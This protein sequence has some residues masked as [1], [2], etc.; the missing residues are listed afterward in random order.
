LITERRTVDVQ[1]TT[2]LKT[3]GMA[4]YDLYAASAFVAQAQRI[5][6]GTELDP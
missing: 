5:G 3:V 2:V 6:R 4:L 1:R